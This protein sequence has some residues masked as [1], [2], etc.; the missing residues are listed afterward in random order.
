LEKM[1]FLRG[2]SPSGAGLSF[3]REKKKT[4]EQAFKREEGHFTRACRFRGM[5][6]IGI[7][8]QERR[9]RV[10]LVRKKKNKG[11]LNH[12]FL[13]TAESFRQ[14]KGDATSSRR[15]GESGKEGS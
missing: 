15:R 13:G 2:P 14:K 7:L 4:E 8:R 12:F 5:G 1:T 9:C 6:E 11:P 10:R 3:T